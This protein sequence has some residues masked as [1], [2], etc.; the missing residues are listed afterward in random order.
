MYKAEADSFWPVSTPARRLLLHRRPPCLAC[1]VC[2]APTPPLHCSFLQQVALL[3]LHKLPAFL[4]GLASASSHCERLGAD[5]SMH[6]VL[7]AHAT[8]Q[9]CAEALVATEQ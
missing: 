5:G 8:C 7:R 3:H 4:A 9:A 1:C 6:Q 2:S